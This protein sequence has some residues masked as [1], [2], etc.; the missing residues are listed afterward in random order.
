MKCLFHNVSFDDG[1]DR[2][3]IH[4]YWQMEEQKKEMEKNKVSKL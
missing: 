1:C 2:F 3:M 4:D